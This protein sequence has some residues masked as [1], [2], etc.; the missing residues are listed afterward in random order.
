MLERNEKSEIDLQRVWL[1]MGRQRPAY[2]QDS[3]HSEKA[4]KLSLLFGDVA[5]VVL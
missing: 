5:K 4:E 1:L 3:Y 2:L